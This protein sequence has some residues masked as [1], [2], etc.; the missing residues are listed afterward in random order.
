MG[1]ANLT[2][3]SC[4][5]AKISLKRLKTNDFYEKSQKKVSIYD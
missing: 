2:N 5:K 3:F 4:K 1:V